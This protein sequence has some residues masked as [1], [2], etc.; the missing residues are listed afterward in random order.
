[1]GS[2]PARRLPIGETYNLRDVGG[3]PVTGGGTTVW[4]KLFRSDYPKMNDAGRPE[5]ARLRLRIVVDLRAPSERAAR[6]SEVDGLVGRTISQPF[7]VGELIGEDPSLGESLGTLYA[8][9]VHQL[10]TQIAAVVSLL[11]EPGAL[12]ALVHCAAGKDR[13]GI[14]IGLILS[15]I[16]VPDATVAADYALTADYLT[17]DFFAAT[18]P[19][20][21]PAGH[22]DITPLHRAHPAA[23]LDM[24]T[25]TRSL[26]GDVASYL[27]GH[28]VAPQNI[29]RLR[30]ALVDPPGRDN[31]N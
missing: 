31:P 17:P 5:L 28:G 27:T 4:G 2:T 10:G 22:T 25:T 9:A 6:P 29:E 24:L 21:L 11:G 19:A 23:M 1:M 12:P 18:D 3:Y 7:S 16:G 15:A 20:A 13:T 26:A 14:I 30:A 8:A